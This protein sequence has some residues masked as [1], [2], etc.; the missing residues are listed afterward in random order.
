MTCLLTRSGM[1]KFV[2]KFLFQFSDHAPLHLQIYRS[3]EQCEKP[4]QDASSGS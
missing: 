4:G 3:G 1:F 2:K